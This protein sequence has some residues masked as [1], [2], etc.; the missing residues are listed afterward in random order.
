MPTV[1]TDGR[2]HPVA[3]TR[4]ADTR[5]GH[6]AVAAGG[7]L[8]V[9]VTA[10]VPAGATGV[11]VNLTA[12]SAASAGYLTAY[13]CGAAAPTAWNLNVTAGETPANQAVD[14]PRPTVSNLNYD[15]NATAANLA[16]VRLS[17]G[18]TLC[19]ATSTATHLIADIAGW[20]MG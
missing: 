7:V 4:I 3:P 1:G 14:Q 19:L 6:G 8:Q 20:Y 13:P 2:Y 10:T 12:A 15:A 11:V 17:A 5:T 16:T 18:G 9:P